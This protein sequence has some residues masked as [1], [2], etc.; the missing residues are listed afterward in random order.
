MTKLEKTYL[1]IISTIFLIFCIFACTTRYLRQEGWRIFSNDVT[2]GMEHIFAG[3]GVPALLMII[4]LLISILIYQ[5]HNMKN[6]GDQF[7]NSVVYRLIV[8]F[9]AIFLTLD[10]SYSHE[11]IQAFEHVYNG[12]PRGYVQYW[13]IVCDQIGIFSYSTFTIYFYCRYIFN[14]NITHSDRLNATHSQD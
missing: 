4:M 8:F 2:V 3:F 1:K 11:I 10:L 12:Q 5:K 14:T 6:T 7:F 9:I 13:Q